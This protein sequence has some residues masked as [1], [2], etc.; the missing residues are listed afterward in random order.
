LAESLFVQ[1][2]GGLGVVAIVASIFF[3][4]IVGTGSA[5]V[6]AIGLAMIPRMIKS[7]YSP[8][9]SGSLI[10]AAGG[11]GVIIPPSVV[12]IIYAV[13]AQVSI[14]KLFAAGVIPGILVGLFLIGYCM[15]SAQRTQTITQSKA[16]SN[17]QR[18]KALKEA[19]IPLGLPLLILGGI[20]SGLMTPTE[21]AAIGVFYC[22]V[23]GLFFYKT[24]SV[25]SLYHISIESTLLV[26]VALFI[27]GGSVCF[28]RIMTFEEIPQKIVASV[29]YLTEN[30]ILILLGINALL[31][32]VGAFFET[33]AAIVILTPVLLPITNSLGID[34]IH[35]G[36]IMIVN[37]S[38]G[39]ITPPLGANLF[40]ASQ[41]GKIPFDHLARA[42]WPWVFTM[43]LALMLITFIPEI[44]LTLPSLLNR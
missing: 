25:K 1:L 7:G 26:S 35:F 16:F 13:T 29:F 10:S 14:T 33:L 21:S 36:I 3:G 5:T 8:E 28:G 40:M 44:S 6:A 32:V 15:L 43:I 39:F 23:C 2:P 34:P 24:L 11:I 31:L 37:L 18:L 17:S 20:Y 41:V 22:I 12:M 30:K 27:L 42:I 9:Y 4:S 38:I 19:L